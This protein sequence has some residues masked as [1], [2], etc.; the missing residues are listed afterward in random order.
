MS[1]KKEMKKILPS[2]IVKE[3]KKMNKRRFLYKNYLND[4]N[5]YSKYSGMWERSDE[6]QIKAKLIFYSHAI[7]K[8]LS[9][10]NFRVRFGKRAL[11][12]L[13]HYLSK[14]NE[15]NYNLNSMEYL[16]AI[17]VLK[18]YDDKHKNLNVPMPKFHKKFDRFKYDSAPDVAGS[19]V[20][21]LNKKNMSFSELIFER[22]SVREFDDSNV[23]LSKVKNSVEMAIRTPSVCNRQPWKV[24]LTNDSK[25]IKKLLELQGGFKGYTIPPVLSLVTVDLSSFISVTERNEPFV[26][27]GMFVMSFLYALTDNGLASCTLNTMR[28]VPVLDEI[29]SIMGISSSEVLISFIAIGNYKKEYRVAKSHRKNINDIMITD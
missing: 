9:H 27:G 3:I 16:N 17:S 21:Y 11:N 18:A 7:E 6:K 29:K 23:D 15:L 25:R 22:H 2:V 8:G 24:Y 5:G 4:L 10:P 1:I 13:F 12:N 28:P 26:D 19:D 14:Y 20:L